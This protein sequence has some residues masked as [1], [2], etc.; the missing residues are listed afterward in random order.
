MLMEILHLFCTGSVAFTGDFTFTS[1]G[2]FMKKDSTILI[3]ANTKLILNTNDDPDAA[4][5]GSSFRN[6]C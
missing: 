4:A 3:T 1:A 2:F 5:C 6:G